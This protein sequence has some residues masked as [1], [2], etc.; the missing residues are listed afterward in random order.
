MEDT[1]LSPGQAAYERYAAVTEW[2]TWDG[3]EMPAWE[4]LTE[5]IKEAWQAAGGFGGSLVVSPG[6]TLVFRRRSAISRAEMDVIR[7][8]CYDA[9]V[10]ALFVGPEI[11]GIMVL[12][13]ALQS[14][15]SPEIYGLCRVPGPGGEMCNA[16][17]GHQPSDQHS[18]SPLP[19][20]EAEQP[21]Q[22]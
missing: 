3:R 5:K 19:G 10:K 21:E 6:D 20:D 8:Y 14:L 16:L 2:K 15:T 22:P 4:N 7:N 9:G 18:W 1:E 12:R 13:P 17:S 11:D